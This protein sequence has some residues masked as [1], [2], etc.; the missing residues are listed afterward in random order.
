MP[1]EVVNVNDLV[2][3]HAAQSTNEQQT[4][5]ADN[6]ETQQQAAETQEQQT[7][8]QQAAS[9]ETAT[10]EQEV[11]R[12]TFPIS[13]DELKDLGFASFDELKASLK[14]QKEETVSP[15]EQVRLNNLYKVNLQKYAVEE[16][17]MN[18]DDFTKLESFK[19]KSNRDIVL[20]AFITE[21]KGENSNLT[22]AEIKA[23]FDE[24]YPVFDET[25]EDEADSNK[26]KN[27]RI[28][29]RLSKEA[30]II[31]IPLEKS[32]ESIKKEFDNSNNLK[33]E[34]PDYAKKVEAIIKEELPSKF[35][36]FKGKDGEEEVTVGIELNEADKKDISELVSKKVQN[37]ES[38][39]L[40]K[41]GDTAALQVLVK[42]AINEHLWSP[43]YREK[44]LAKMAETFLSRGVKKGSTVGATNPFPVNRQQQ[45][46]TTRSSGDA[47]KEVLDSLNGVNK[48]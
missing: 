9:T 2:L 22:D 40:Y 39:G 30:S 27:K 33:K 41:K 5:S 44:G 29:K 28:E 36:F 12:G 13:E 45:Q 18:P 35:D 20:S 34:F 25:D 6:S 16:G 7:T 31:K 37:L 21:Q 8:T 10:A 47:E 1:D 38:F 19:D 14:K 23:A 11:S 17:K 42:E 24:E 43:S 26:T 15:E 48:Q 32:I 3:Q 4:N 46:T